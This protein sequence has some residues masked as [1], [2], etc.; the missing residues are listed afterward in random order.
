SSSLYKVLRIRSISNFFSGP[1][2]FDKL[3]FDC[4][5]GTFMLSIMDYVFPGHL[6]I[7]CTVHPYKMNKV[8]GS[9]N[10]P[11]V[12]IRA[13][14]EDTLLPLPF[15]LLMSVCLR[16]SC[17]PVVFSLGLLIPILK[18]AHLDARLPS[19]YRPITISSVSGLENPDTSLPP[20][21]TIEHQALYLRATLKI[22]EAQKSFF[23]FQGARL[24]FNGV[25]PEVGSHL[26]SVGV[27]TVLTYRSAQRRCVCQPTSR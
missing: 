13:S 12:T 3:R 10:L 23:G 4:K 2:N 19:N 26:F 6:M 24:C 9:E 17:L 15:F 25:A 27:R 1:M 21:W 22:Q 14:L 7:S 20:E 8:S 18:K 11:C 16:F 5:H